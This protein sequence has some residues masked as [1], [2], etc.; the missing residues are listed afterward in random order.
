MSIDDIFKLIINLMPLHYIIICSR[1]SAKFN[2]ICHNSQFN[3]VTYEKYIKYIS[4]FDAIIISKLYGT[5]NDNPDIVKNK[6]Y[7]LFNDDQHKVKGTQYKYYIVDNDR[8]I[9]GIF[10]QKNGPILINDYRQTCVEYTIEMRYFNDYIKQLSNNIRV[11]FE[12]SLSIVINFNMKLVKSE[13]KYIISELHMLF[14]IKVHKKRK[15]IIIHDTEVL[16]FGC[17][18]LTLISNSMN[19]S[20]LICSKINELYLGLCNKHLSCYF[21]DESDEF[22]YLSCDSKIQES[23]DEHKIMG[24]PNLYEIENVIKYTIIALSA[25]GTVLCAYKMLNKI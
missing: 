2:Y 8:K 20:M 22:K 19:K 21:D 7:E 15:I 12:N 11:Q 18:S 10:C 9:T 17:I 16:F 23:N 4:N 25:I 24:Y 13:I 14:N 6:I 1:I 3:A 5:I